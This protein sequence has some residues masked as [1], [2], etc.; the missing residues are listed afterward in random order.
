MRTATSLA[1]V[2]IGA[3]FAF[4]ITQSP[5]FLNL[6]VV[7]W[8]LMLTGAAGAVIPRRGYG[9]LRRS[10]VVKNQDRAAATDVVEEPAMQPQRFSR[11]LAPGGL[12]SVR[13]RAP[14]PNGQVE[15]ETIDQYIEE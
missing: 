14:Q 2:A 7:G 15:R 13:H 12:I 1:L 5:S 10:L 8:V 6:Q 4:A 11:W 3:I 9:W